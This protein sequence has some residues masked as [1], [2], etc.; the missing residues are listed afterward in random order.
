MKWEYPDYKIDWASMPDNID[1]VEF[2]EKGNVVRQFRRPEPV[3]LPLTEAQAA[4]LLMV[5]NMIGG[6]PARSRRRHFNAI[7]DLL[8]L[9]G[10]PDDGRPAG[11]VTGSITF[12]D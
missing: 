2:S 3:L 7:H 11:A 5:T 9:L 6:D 8:V 1:Q 4:A 12:K 10:V